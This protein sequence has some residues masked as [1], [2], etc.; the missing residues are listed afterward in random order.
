[1]EWNRIKS[2]W[3]APFDK[4]IVDESFE[5]CDNILGKWNDKYSALLIR[6]TFNEIIISGF[7]LGHIQN[8]KEVLLCA[9]MVWNSEETTVMGIRWW[10][11]EV[12]T[13]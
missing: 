10:V 4:W 6:D 2:A 9:W 3:Q 11:C 8:L 5:S 13:H 12:C 1:M 7:F